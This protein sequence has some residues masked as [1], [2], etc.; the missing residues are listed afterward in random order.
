MLQILRISLILIVLSGTFDVFSQDSFSST[1]SDPSGEKEKILLARYAG[2]RY[3]S[4]TIKLLLFSDS[5]YFYSSRFQSGASFSDEGTYLIVDST[6][7]LCSRDYVKSNKTRQEVHAIFENMTYSL[8]GDKII[9]FTADDM[10][11]DKIGFL[12]DYYTL[13][14]EQ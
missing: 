12:N 8:I 4:Q 9:L 14:K 10:K 2:G 13:I 1:I 6:I 3:G 5:T 11:H 7:T